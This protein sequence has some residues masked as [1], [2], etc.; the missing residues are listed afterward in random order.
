MKK[1]FA[2]SLIISV[3]MLSM[4]WTGVLA[5][6]NPVAIL[7]G[8]HDLLMTPNGTTHVHE[9]AY[10]ESQEPFKQ[11][12]VSNGYASHSLYKYYNGV[13][14]HCAKEGT[15]VVIGDPVAHTLRYTGSNQHIPGE[16][17]HKYFY[18]CDACGYTTYDTL[19]CPGTGNGDCIIITPGVLRVAV[20]EVQ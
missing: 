1:F 16:S 10:F 5:E 2:C 4:T 11:N 15:V 13:C 6:E 7:I 12:Y 9:Y 8:K 14:V 17:R 19:L 3:L 20:T 18:V